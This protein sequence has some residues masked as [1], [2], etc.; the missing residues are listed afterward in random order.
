MRN[1]SHTGVTP[2][3]PAPLMEIADGFRIAKVLAA[4]LELELFALL[5]RAGV[6]TPEELA[7][8]L[9]IERRPA[10]MLLVGAASL[11]LLDRHGEHGYRNAPIAS[12]F[13]VPGKRYYFGDLIRFTDRREYSAWDRLEWALRENKPTTWDSDQAESVFDGDG[14]VNDLFWNAL[15]SGA[16]FTARALAL[17]VEFSAY[18][19]LL[20]VGG[21]SGAFC[22]EIT[23]H[24]PKLTASVYDVPFV[25]GLAEKAIAEADAAERVDTVAGDFWK[26]DLPAGY[27]VMLLS[28]VLHD[29]SDQQNRV[30]LG[31]CNAAL[32]S[33]GE[34][35]IAESFVDDNGAGPV[36]GAVSSLNML[37]E[38]AEGQNYTR[39]EYEAALRDV[40]FTD[41]RR[42]DFL[43]DAPG[44]N[45]ALIARK[46]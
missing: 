1:P 20:D 18:S 29:W 41:I 10:T 13:L 46:P 4:A 26:E 23:S 15:Y 3:T 8:E 44:A 33:G 11:G 7:A 42:V 22:I 31:K 28:N 32:P 45:G 21:G 27:D 30:L 24:H 43:I 12:E 36:A 17:S 14:M 34:V 35:I 38:T 5:D 37:I 19:R 39:A 25:T 16:M 40:G 9:G 6:L 2:L